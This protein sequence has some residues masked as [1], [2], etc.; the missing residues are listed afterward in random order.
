MLSHA[1]VGLLA[2]GGSLLV[3]GA[4]DEGAGSAATPL[5]ELFREVHSVASGGRCRLV[6]ATSPTAGEPRPRMD[7]WCLRFDPGREELGTSWVSF[8][9]VFAHGRLD[10]GT[11]LLLD[12]SPPA[13]EGA[14]VLDFACGHGAIGATVRA[15]EPTAAVSFLDVDAL[16]LE[17]ARRNV[18]GALT[19][20]SDGWNAAGR[21]TWDLVV[22]NPPWHAG[23]QESLTVLEGLVAGAARRLVVGGGLV[24]VTQR[25]LPVEPL[26]AEAF[27]RVEVLGDDGPWR[28][29]A[30]RA[31]GGGTE[32]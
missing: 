24:F 5:G 3:Y 4:N 25:R 16:A 11:R 31:R 32:G 21:S 13:R 9:G 15:R 18:P 10:G 17:A 12:V 14:R 20:L 7:D 19:L 8:P 30:A 22:S 2:P 26:L 23:K 1:A 29:W 27:E 28:V 6:V